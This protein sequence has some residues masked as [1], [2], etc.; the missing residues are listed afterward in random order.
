MELTTLGILA[1]WIEEQKPSWSERKV[2]LL[3]N[4]DGKFCWPL[5]GSV[6]KLSGTVALFFT[7]QPKWVWPPQ[8]DERLYVRI[9]VS[10]DMGIDHCKVLIENAVEQVAGR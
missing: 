2:F 1:V 3:E 7:E 8:A 10:F 6:G 5:L 4:P 9:D